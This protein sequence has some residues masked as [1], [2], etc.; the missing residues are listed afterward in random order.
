MKK[1]FLFTPGPTPVPTSALLS[2]ARPVDYHRSD[3]A[4][5]M[6]DECA[7]KL[8]HVFQTEN[9]V[10]ILTSSGTGAM[11][12]AV[13]NLLSP[14]DKVITIESGKFGQRWCEICEAYGVEVDLIQLEWGHTVP[15]ELVADLLEKNP[16]IKAV[17]ATLCETSTG[18]LH[19]IKSLGEITKDTDT[20]LVVDAISG[21]GA[22]ELRMDEWCVDTV[23]SCTQKG[24]M[25]PPGLGFVAMSEKAW[26]AANRSKLPKY[27]FDLRKAREKIKLGST[28]YTPAITF[29]TALSESL[30]LI[31]EEGIE[32][33]WARH[34]KLAKATQ[35]GVKAI[36]LELFAEVP[37]NT[38]TSV[39]FPEMIDSKDFVKFMRK[40]HG[41][42]FAGGQDYLAGK[43]I[44]IA[45]LGWSCEYDVLTAL[46][47]LEM[48]LTE[49]GYKLPLGAGITAAEKI[50]VL[51][52][53]NGNF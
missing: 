46:S 23:V 36:G 13:A 10:M 20:L 31:C 52:E 21:L 29:I 7:Q 47:A 28:P 41:V 16:D 39:R 33:V 30:K 3:E 25:T 24:L 35:A 44:R 43:I 12:S 37:A 5:K 40:Q 42:T 19:D 9:D 6:I 17:F 48:G 38:V 14:M 32:N 4:V 27:Y 45:H 11:E 2:L 49:M 22:D 50:M 15:P 34:N 18:C 26:D 1:K 51:E 8:K 53:N